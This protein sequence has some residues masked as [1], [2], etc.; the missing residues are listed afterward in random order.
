MGLRQHRPR[1][2]VES[3]PRFQRFPGSPKPVRSSS[4]APALSHPARRRI[5][6]RLHTGDGLRSASQLAAELGLSRNYVSYHV[7]VLRDLGL[8]WPVGWIAVRGAEEIFCCSLVDRDPQATVILAE[9]QGN[10]EG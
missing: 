3:D 1:D 9:T 2:P 5:L 8:I 10:D 6:R 7:K 4:V